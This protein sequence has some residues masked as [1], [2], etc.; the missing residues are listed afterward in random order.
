MNIF[1]ILKYSIPCLLRGPGVLYQDFFEIDFLVV[2][3]K[4]E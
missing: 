4:G 3:N 1:M 2:F